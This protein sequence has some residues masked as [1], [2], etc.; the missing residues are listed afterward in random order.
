MGE[1]N[2]LTGG[3]VETRGPG[4]NHLESIGRDETPLQEFGIV[5]DVYHAVSA[6]LQHDGAVPSHPGAQV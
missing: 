6:T 3:E 2:P 4:E 1:P 5:G